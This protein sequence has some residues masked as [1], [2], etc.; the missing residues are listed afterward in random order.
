MHALFGNSIGRSSASSF[1]WNKIN[2]QFGSRLIFLVENMKMNQRSI[3][4][5]NGKVMK[6]WQPSMKL[7]LTQAQLIP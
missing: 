5:K 3:K 1:E 6:T 4:M 7:R 2:M